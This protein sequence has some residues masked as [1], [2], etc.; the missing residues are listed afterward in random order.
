M[1][2]SV[3]SGNKI[4]SINTYSEFRIGTLLLEMG[5]ISI[6]DAQKVMRLHNEQGLRFG[7]VAKNLGLITDADIQEVLSRQFDYKY[8]TTENVYSND[9]FAAYQPFSPQVEMLRAVRSQLMLRWF[10]ENRKSLALSSPKSGEGTS[11]FIANLAVV[12]SQ[13]GKNTLL[14]D[15]NLRA[16]S[17]NTI[18]NL[19]SKQGLSD[20]LIGRAGIDAISNIR[21]FEK[22][23]V[24]TAGTIPPNPQEMVSGKGFAELVKFFS[25]IYDVVLIDS[26]AFS[27]GA[28]AQTIA[29]ISG[30]ILLV[31]R[32][33][34]T[35]SSLLADIAEQL[36]SHGTP[37]VGSVLV[38]F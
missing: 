13:L 7:D 36:E 9:L 4:P 10:N 8:L 2:D 1:S 12:F 3:S 11:R 5:K 32:K 34:K 6:E 16:P 26:P 20:V 31:A 24:L 38:D 14:I 22:L 17:Q 29:S 23:S 15:A 19:T 27:F 21:H 30:G 33:D 18:F 35:Q 28:D 25:N 37:I